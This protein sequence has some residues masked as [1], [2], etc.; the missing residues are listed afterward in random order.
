MQLNPTPVT[1][2][3]GAGSHARS[4]FIYMRHYA[5]R[6]IYMVYSRFNEPE[7]DK[8]IRDIGEKIENTLAEIDHEIDVRHVK[9]NEKNFEESFIAVARIYDQEKNTIVITDLT[10]G[11]KIISYIMF[12]AHCYSRHKLRD[13]NKL[14]YFFKG[15]DTPHEMPALFVDRL[16]DKVERFLHDIF[17]YGIAKQ[18]NDQNPIGNF[19]NTMFKWLEVNGSQDYTEPTM[20]RYKKELRDRGFV[21][22][23]SDKVTVK[24]KMYLVTMEP[25]E[26]NGDD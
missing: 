15:D 13:G 14:V 20:Y 9:V 22:R 3:C 4:V 21:E 19:Q 6:K 12:Y 8:K 26:E 25:I 24:G 1:L 18:L 17:R 10:A 2:I 23:E 11:H 5:V 16:S 7:Y